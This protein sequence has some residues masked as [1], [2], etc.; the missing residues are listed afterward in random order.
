M[1]D[2]IKPLPVCESALFQHLLWEGTLHVHDQL[3]HLIVGLAREQDLAS[4]QLI[5]HTTHTPDVQGVVCRT[6]STH[7]TA[8]IMNAMLQAESQADWNGNLQER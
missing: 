1:F 8:A 5:D 3:Q 4:E 6:P 2:H 7:L